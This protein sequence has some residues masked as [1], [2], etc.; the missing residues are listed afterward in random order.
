ME[1]IFNNLQAS[2]E[3]VAALLAL[4]G[5]VLA[6]ATFAIKWFKLKVTGNKYAGFAVHVILFILSN[7]A[8]IGGHALALIPVLNGTRWAV[9][10]PALMGAAVFVRELQQSKYVQMALQFL[11]GLLPSRS[12][13]TVGATDVLEVPALQP[14]MPAILAEQLAQGAPQQP[15]QFINS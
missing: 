1:A 12:S 15:A 7:L 4:G 14:I 6:T 3:D 5:S 11:K 13:S 2:P 8:V 10:V 9:Y